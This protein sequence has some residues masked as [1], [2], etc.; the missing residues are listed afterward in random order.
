MHF[1]NIGESLGKQMDVCFSSEGIVSLVSFELTF[2]VDYHRASTVS[3]IL[4]CDLIK[5]KF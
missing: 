2:A 5:E 4:L 1:E 3:P